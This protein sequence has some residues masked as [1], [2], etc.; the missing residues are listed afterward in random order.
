M[1]PLSYDYVSSVP[2]PLRHESVPAAPLL[3][4]L[5]LAISTGFSLWAMNYILVK[6]DPSASA[7][8][9]ASTERAKLERRLGRR[10]VPPCY[11]TTPSALVRTPSLR[12]RCRTAASPV[13]CGIKLAAKCCAASSWQRSCALQQAALGVLPHGLA[14]IRRSFMTGLVAKTLTLRASA[15]SRTVSAVSAA[16][17]LWQS[18]RRRWRRR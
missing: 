12:W 15:E 4:V 11:S 6:M 10:F 2:P 14:Y 5:S 9:A 17:R 3:Q 1:H 18:T 7:K 16:Y 8:A 13:L